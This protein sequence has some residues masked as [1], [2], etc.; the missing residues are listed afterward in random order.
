[1]LETIRAEEFERDRGLRF[2]GYRVTIAS[3]LAAESGDEEKH[4][5]QIASFARAGSTP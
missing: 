4:A 3:L 1:M 2:R 5:S